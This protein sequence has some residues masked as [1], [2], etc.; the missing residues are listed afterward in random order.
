MA[1]T[2]SSTFHRSV[3]LLLFILSWVSLA[4]VIKDSRGLKPESKVR[5]EHMNDLQYLSLAD[6]AQNEFFLKTKAMST[7]IRKFFSANI[8]LRMRKFSR[9]HAA[10]SNRFQPSTCIRF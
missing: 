6:L 9:P 4:M 1:K 10:Y 2:N 8:F 5:S 7:R 3:V